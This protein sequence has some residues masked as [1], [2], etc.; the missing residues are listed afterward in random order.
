MR[1]LV[2]RWWFWA[3]LVSAL[4]ALPL[5][6]VF[7]RDPPV[8]PPVRGQA[9][10]F[11]LTRETGVPFGSRD[12]ANKVWVVSRFVSEDETPSMKAMLHL[13]RHMRKLGDAFMLVSIVVDPARDTQQV[14][15][16]AAKHHQ[17]NP[18][19][20]ALCTGPVDELKR[21]RS[22]LQIDPSRRATDPLVLI[23]AHGRIRGVY[24]LGS[25]TA[26]DAKSTLEQL[27]YDAALLVNDY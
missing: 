1:W 26:D 4:F 23:D 10:E 12:L 15:A 16:D 24:D 5:V 19:R 8:L 9:P 22:E 14:L 6:R 27:I 21:I 17:T 11:T 7:S 25:G 3:L 13:Q 18:R 2:G 20:W